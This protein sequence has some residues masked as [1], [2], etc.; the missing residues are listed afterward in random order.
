M[1][2]LAAIALMAGLSTGAL[3]WPQRGVAPALFRERGLFDAALASAAGV[4]PLDEVAALIVPHHLLAADLIA[5]GFALAGGQRPER[6]VLIGPDHYH[7]GRTL[8]SVDLRD[9]ETV[10]GTVPADLDGAAALLKD[11][12]VS[13]S[14]LFARDH[15]FQALLPFI[16]R[17]W[18]GVPVLAVAIGARARADTWQAVAAA[19]PAGGLLVTSTDFSHYLP[20]AQADERDRR[21]LAVLAAGDPAGASSLDQPQNTDCRGAL[22]VTLARAAGAVVQVQRNSSYYAGRPVLSS[23]SYMVVTF[24][25]T[26]RTAPAPTAARSPAPR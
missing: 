16:A 2:A 6:I 10:Y 5:R 14:S 26:A 15:A 17:R 12:R 25:R 21:T 9:F 8:V 23:T 22:Y 1:K 24:R 3:A 7:R 19:L 4:R 11:R 13:A 18:P 20:T